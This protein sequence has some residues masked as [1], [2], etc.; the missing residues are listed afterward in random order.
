MNESFF[1]TKITISC[2]FLVFQV[3][4][5]EWLGTFHVFI[6]LATLSISPFYLSIPSFRWEH[7][8]R[9]WL[10]H[11]SSEVTI[12]SYNSFLALSLFPLPKY[13]LHSFLIVLHFL[14]KLPSLPSL[15]LIAPGNPLQYSCLENPHRQ[16]SLEGYSPWCRNKPDTTEQHRFPT[17]I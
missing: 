15:L 7:L 2:I 13:K 6:F 1:L 3:F 17:Y 4:L 12:F 14:P 10:I 11:F 8:V 5:C 9:N 16:R